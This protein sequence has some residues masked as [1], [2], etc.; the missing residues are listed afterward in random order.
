VNHRTKVA[1]VHNPS[2]ANCAGEPRII[3]FLCRHVLPSLS[4][5][6]DESQ[7]SI[8]GRHFRRRRR[9]MGETHIDALG[10]ASCDDVV[11]I[12]RDGPPT[13]GRY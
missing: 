9:G 7:Y 8:L 11:Q 12:C 1:S 10:C 2:D 13:N 5:C 6:G 4:V 3:V